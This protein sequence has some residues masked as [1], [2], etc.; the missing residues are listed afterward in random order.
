[1]IG[2][3]IETH[4]WTQQMVSLRHNGTDI[5]M[6]HR[7]YDSM[8][9]TLNRSSQK[10]VR[11]LYSEMYMTYDIPSLTKELFAVDIY[12][13]RVMA[14]TKQTPCFFLFLAYSLFLSLFF[15]F[16]V[17]LS[18]FACLV[19]V[20]LF[21]VYV[22][23]L[24]GDRISL[25]SSGSPGTHSEDQAGLELRHLP[26]SIFSVIGLKVYAT[27]ACCLCFFSLNGIKKKNTVLEDLWGIGIGQNM[28]MDTI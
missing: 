18:L 22:R 26:V 17:L 25:C 4:N 13:E 15:P 8:H 9:K 16:Q 2:I 5:H 21:Y 14:K 23:G 19:F 11:A 20:S 27:T 6:N 28:V 24:F 1:M 3:N 12:W 7:E 10:W